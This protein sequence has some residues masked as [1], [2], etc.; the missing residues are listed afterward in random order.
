MKDSTLNQI[1]ADY[2]N[3]YREIVFALLFGSQV[4]GKTRFNSDIDI[5]ICFKNEPDI[6]MMGQIIAQLESLTN[7]R[8]D[9]VV[10]NALPTKNPLLAYNITGSHDVL[11]CH[12]VKQYETFKFRSYCE[13]FDF[14]PVL[15][16]Q[17]AKLIEELQNGNF[18]KTKT[19]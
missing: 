17:N 16:E 11:V 15:K 7:N 10:L 8:I 9:L 1:L 3:E 5:A 4:S 14:E 13:Y 18:G 19:A 2:L 6:L 12:D